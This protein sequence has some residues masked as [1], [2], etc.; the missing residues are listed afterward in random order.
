MAR[1]E[2]IEGKSRDVDLDSTDVQDTVELF[3]AFYAARAPSQDAIKHRRRR[4]LGG[5]KV[6]VTG[7]QCQAVRL[8]HRGDP[9]D[10]N[11]KVEILGHLR[12]NA[13]LLVVFLAEKCQ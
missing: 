2:V 4:A 12:D 13:Q 9:N 11:G 3:A 6:C 1:L 5:R 7:G 8:A 10:L